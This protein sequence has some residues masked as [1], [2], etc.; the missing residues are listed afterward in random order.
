MSSTQGA[1]P[2]PEP[3]FHRFM[4]LPPELR[5]MIWH[6]AADQAGST[7]PMVLPLMY[8]YEPYWEP[9][10]SYI[11]IPRRWRSLYLQPRLRA[12]L[13][14]LHTCQEARAELLA[15]P[16]SA[17]SRRRRVSSSPPSF[18]SSPSPPSPP[19]YLLSSSSQV[20][21]PKLPPPYRP[22]Y[23]LVLA[24]QLGISDLESEESLWREAF[25]NPNDAYSST[26]P[27]GLASWPHDPTFTSSSGTPFEHLFPSLDWDRRLFAVEWRRDVLVLSFVEG[28]AAAVWR[29]HP[30]GLPAALGQAAN[31]VVVHD[32]LRGS[33]PAWMRR[34]VMHFGPRLRGL[35][36]VN[37][38][39]WRRAEQVLLRVVGRNNHWREEG[40]E[41]EHSST[42]GDGGRMKGEDGEEAETVDVASENPWDILTRNDREVSR[43]LLA[44]GEVS[45]E[46]LPVQLGLTTEIVNGWSTPVRV[47]TITGT[48]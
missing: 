41:G 43:D 35:W 37:R 21:L 46:D 3:A 45:I 40:E 22:T 17:S 5:L 11:H 8:A 13:A 1:S 19:S 12:R 33:P 31:V 30:H 20:S 44:R 7:G 18:S 16:L 24:P 26:I 9:P 27:L 42:S 6:M 15:P 38:R 14:L 36:F 4:H 23:Q 10:R 39:V 47:G 28:A 2:P 34:V 25:T 32:Y 29:W 48:R